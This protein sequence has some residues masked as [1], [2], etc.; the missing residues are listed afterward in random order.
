MSPALLFAVALCLECHDGSKAPKMESSHPVGI[1]YAT[2]AAKNPRLRKSVSED[3]LVDGKVECT[4]CHLAHEVATKNAFRL[5]S[6]DLIK[7][8]TSCHVME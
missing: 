5:R 7:L 8:C 2:A 4:T 1:V 3:L 6:T